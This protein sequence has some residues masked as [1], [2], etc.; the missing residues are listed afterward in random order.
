L[1]A[2][3]EAKIA[4]A[5]W[6]EALAEVPD[7]YLPRAYEQAAANWDWTDRRNAFTPD[8]VAERYR[9]LVVEDRQRIEADR[10]NAAR[11]NPETY[12][13]W[14]CCD[15]GYQPVFVRE[16]ERWYQAVRPCSCEIA[17]MGQRSAEPLREPEFI[18]NR[19]GEYVSRADLE[20]YGAPSDLFKDFIKAKESQA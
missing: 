18:R 8:S 13:C 5:A 15:L 16:R 17:P 2:G 1:T 12:Q 19:L 11:K 3:S 20:R 7:N 9:L 4:L 10:R 6:E 14:H